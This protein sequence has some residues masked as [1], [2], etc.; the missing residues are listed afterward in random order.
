MDG[1]DVASLAMLP[2]WTLM[3]W[4]GYNAFIINEPKETWMK[5]IDFIVDEQGK[6][7]AAIID[8]SE[9]REALEDVFDLIVA[10]KR[11]NEPSISLK[12]LKR[13]VAGKK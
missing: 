2:D 12:T 9:H 4:K 8:I 3:H 13:R 11:R 6:R 10:R 7:K 1:R 5:G